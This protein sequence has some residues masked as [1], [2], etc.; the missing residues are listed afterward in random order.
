M[1]TWD[2]IFKAGTHTSSDGRTR[3]WTRDDLDKLVANTGDEAPIVIRH[4][5]DQ[6]KAAKFG[7][8]A[9]LKR[10]DDV[11]KAQ[12]GDV[13][14]MLST[15]VSEGLKL[16]K[17]VSID[18][19]TMKI[20]HVGLLGADQPPA[21]DGLGAASFTAFAA[22]DDSNLTYTFN[23]TKEEPGMDP[24]DK[25]IEELE[26]KIKELEAKL[27]GNEAEKKLEHAEKALKDE[28]DAH[29]KTKDEFS[30]YKQTQAD[31]AL[32]GRVNALADS[33]RI[34][35]N[36]KD[37]VLAFAKALPGEEATMTFSAADGKTEQVTPRENY[38]RDFEARNPDQDG[39]L[40][41]FANGEGAGKG[42]GETL[43]L[44]EVN[45]YA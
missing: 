1:A 25:K 14:E 16:G 41:E 5:K 12:Y 13:S 35:P 29:K 30:A 22:A 28:K 19:D 38:L 10:F 23:Q 21:V 37:K 6:D 44:S 15:A 27:A 32:E 39:L 26:K 17:S 3:T 20:R 42:R 4:P 9:A 24:K 36:E 11:L 18:P 7:K 40:S 2:P 33:G 8:I 34:H 43:D 31:E 45:N